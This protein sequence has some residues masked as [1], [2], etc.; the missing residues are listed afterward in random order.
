MNNM[1]YFELMV[2]AVYAIAKLVKLVDKVIE[3]IKEEVK[4]NKELA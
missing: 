4:V 1:M 3:T 2:I